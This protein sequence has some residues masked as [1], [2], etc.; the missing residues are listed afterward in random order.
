MRAIIYARASLDRT[1]EGQSTE[2]QTEECVRLAEYKRWDVVAKE[3]DLSISAYGDKERP[4]WLRVLAAIEAGEVDVVVAYH[5]DRLTRNMAD[6]EKLILVC[7]KHNVLVATATGDIDLTNDTG[8]MVA[9]ILAAVARQEVERKAARQ[10]LAHVQRRAQ[11]RPWAGTKMLGYTRRGEIIPE[12]AEAIRDAAKAVLDDG[13]SLSELGRRWQALGLESPYK[14]KDKPWSPR[15]V[16]NVLTNPRLA[17]YITK[18]GEVLGKGEWEA[19]VDDMTMTLLLSVLNAADRTSGTN[20]SSG[21]IAS[22]LLTG[23]M[24]CG[25]CGST[26]RAGSKRGEETYACGKWHATVNRAE[27][28]ELV[29]SAFASAV[30]LARPESILGGTTLT[31]DSESV[32]KEIAALQARQADLAMSFGRG[33][34]PLAI[35][36]AAMVDLTALIDSLMS[37]LKAAPAEA[38]W[39]AGRAGAVANF[40]DQSVF[41]QRKVL[42]RMATIRV[43]PSGRKA[44]GAAWQIEVLVRGKRGETDIEIPAHMPGVLAS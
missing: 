29:R 8:R 22:N 17:G 44:T 27:A 31:V 28:D 4:A 40:L 10:K 42:A 1:G 6:L 13:V 37:R 11:G 26:V 16:K 2:R 3:V 18:D 7:E 19:I 43:H 24:V 9:R 38:D 14:D 41:D 21:R 15:G 20:K 30:S 33:A 36:E 23:I 12:E 35:F 5:L 39:I 34:I 25:K 32:G